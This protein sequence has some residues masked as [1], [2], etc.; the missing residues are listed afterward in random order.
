M[1]GGLHI[2]QAAF[3]SIGSLLQQSGWTHALTASDVASPGTADS[4][5]STTSIA[6]TRQAHQI[7]SATLYKQLKDAHSDFSIEDELMS[8]SEWIEVRKNPVRSL[9]SGT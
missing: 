2:E 9:T 1:F 6:R 3:K 8:L 5:L 4:Y 7:S